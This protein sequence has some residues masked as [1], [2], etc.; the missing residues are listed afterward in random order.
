MSDQ[1]IEDA[2]VVSAPEVKHTTMVYM[3]DGKSFETSIP[4]Q[5]LVQHIAYNNP[6]V[7]SLNRPT[8]GDV[9]LVAENINYI[10]DVIEEQ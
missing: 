3:I 5:S 10:E 6:R 7:V 1:N 9:H 4:A 2:N 8:G